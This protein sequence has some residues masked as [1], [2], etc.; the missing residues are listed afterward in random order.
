MNN[1][2]SPVSTRLIG[3][4]IPRVEDERLLRGSGCFIDDIPEPRDLL[5][6]VFVM[7]P[8]AHGRITAVHTDG[9]RS[10]D[11]VVDVLTGKDFVGLV[12]PIMPDYEQPGYQV[13]GRPVIATDRVRFV[14]ELVAVVIATS[15]YIAEDAAELVEFECEVLPTVVDAHTARQPDAIKLHEHTRDNVLFRSTFKTDR[16]D[17]AFAAADHVV[18]DRFH[19]ERLAAV[20]IE[21]RGCLAIY[22]H[23][24]DGLTFWTST[25]I[26]HLVRTA[27][28]DLLTWNEETLRVI[29]PD[30]GGGFGMKAYLYPEEVVAAA[31]ARRYRRPVKWISDRRED[32]LTS[33]QSRDYDYDMA[34]A[35]KRDGTLLAVEA[36]IVCN[37]GAYPTFPFGCSVEA[38]GAALFTPGPYRLNQFAFE[39]CAVATNLCPTGAYRGIA[40]PIAAWATETLMDRAAHDLGLDPAEIRIKNVIKDHEF[41]YVNVLGITYQQGS[42][43]T[44]LRRALDVVGYDEFRSQQP[45]DRLVDGKYRGI[46][47]ACFIEHTGQGS[48]RYRARGMLRLPGF[49]SALVRIEPNGK[50]EAYISHATQGQ[51]H[52]TTF[53]QIIAEQLGMAVNDVTV[54]EGDTG[55]GS[56]GTGTFASR[57]AVTGG[58]A[59]LRAAV[60]VAEKLRR[61]AGH[62]LE[63]SPTDIELG[64]NHAYVT[65]VSELRVSIRE[66]AAIA[67]SMSSRELPPGESYGLEA[68]EYYDPP[69]TSITNATHI[70]RVAIDALTGLVDIERYIV[71]H[72]SGRIINPQIVE[73]QIQG[74]IVQGLGSVLYEAIRHDQHG[75]PLQASLMDYL[76]PTVA[77]VPDIEVLHQE[78]WATDTAGGF[79]GVGEGG[80]IGA[81]PALAVAIADALKISTKRVNKLPL[82]PDEIVALIDSQ[83]NSQT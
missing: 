15:R 7:S 22:E 35:F 66:L 10:V 58:G 43:H 72:D 70:A 77:D 21:P 67:Y 39:T 47:I 76:L 82:R 69:R 41:P 32:L 13:V 9:A 59:A 3:K 31:L 20:S 73:G 63:V 17:S 78:T 34:M 40:A 42:F 1:R 33:T 65:G 81:V 44:C 27:L 80:T 49:D 64:G 54:V 16:F 12:K 75:Q 62:I 37:I 25:Q 52:L 23:A 51:G 48:S 14:G 29:A 68:T 11:G 6:L 56:Y 60:F 5:H 8:Y 30:V 71:V 83:P 57:S 26:P 24:R 55:R 46:G 53:A 28:S 2:V 74:G 61:L 45:M 19:S 79:K 38:G 36:Q 18:R 50:A 4:P